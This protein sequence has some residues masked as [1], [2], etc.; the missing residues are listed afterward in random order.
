MTSLRAF[1]AGMIDYAGLFPPASLEMSSAVHKYAESR[2]GE[3][4]DLLGKFVVPASRLEEFSAVA[5]ALL[6]RHG[7]PWRMSVLADDD[8]ELTKT[9]IEH[10]NGA[11]AAESHAGHAV[12]D[13]VELRVSSHDDIRNAVRTFDDD[14]SLYL[15]VSPT[16]EPG[17][18]ISAIA[19][20]PA[21]AKLRTGGVVES[22]IPSPDHVLKFIELCV[23]NGVPFKA[24]AGLHH[25]IRG[26]YPLTYER[27]APTATMFGYLNI[28]FAAAFC[29][30]GSSPSAVMGA[31]EETDASQFRSDDVGVWWKDHVVIHD[32]LSVVRQA[33]ATS[34]GSC[35]FSEPVEEAR[36]LN[37]I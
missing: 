23:D 32:Q 12:C 30:A 34:F 13:T 28:F 16:A 22:A 25:A 3:D 18:L 37:L 20:T 36:N 31:L 11:H 15:E 5:S 9:L 2:S 4:A 35:S 14:V 29:A 6:P 17:Y 27:N 10:F 8:L 7:A 21:S 26:R 19:D 33:V 1:F 24:T